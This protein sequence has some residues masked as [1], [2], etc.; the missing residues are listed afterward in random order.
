MCAMF[1]FFVPS[2]HHRIPCGISGRVR[3]VAKMTDFQTNDGLE[4]LG[5]H[6]F[7]ST[8]FKYIRI[9]GFLRK[10]A[11]IAQASI[12]TWCAYQKLSIRA[13]WSLG[14]SF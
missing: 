8:S 6:H 13:F 2:L 1:C 14:L 12:S 9:F 7:L 3:D 4:G 5:T 11:N 10:C